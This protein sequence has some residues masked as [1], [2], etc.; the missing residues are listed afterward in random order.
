MSLD[1]RGFLNACGSFGF[2]STL[3]PGVLYSIASQAQAKGEERITAD[4]IK[5]AATVAGV[6][7][8]PDQVAA[9]LPVTQQQPQRL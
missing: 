8:E 3:L 5:E 9:M 2:A 1:R 6:S 7:I 4:M